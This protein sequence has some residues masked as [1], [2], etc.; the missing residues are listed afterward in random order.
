MTKSF[1]GY[2]VTIFLFVLIL[3]SAQIVSAQQT[4]TSRAEPPLGIEQKEGQLHQDGH[5]MW[6]G[7]NREYYYFDPG[8]SKDSPLPLVILF[9][10][11]GGTID[12]LLGLDGSKSAAKIWLDVAERERFYLVIPQGRDGRWNDCRS[13]CATCPE[14]NDVG[15]IDTIISEMSS[16]YSINSNRIY[17][18]GIS[19]GGMFSFRLARELSHRIA[20]V[21]TVIANTPA[22]NE[23]SSPNLPVPVMMI[24]GTND[25]IVPYHGGQSSFQNTGTFL[26]AAETANFWITHN[27]CSNTPEIYQFPDGSF[28][29]NSTVTSNLYS[30][31]REG[32]E[33]MVYHVAGGGHTAPSIEEQYSPI[34]EAIVGK[35]NHDIETA[36]EIWSFF[37]KYQLD[38]PLTA[39]GE[40]MK[41]AIMI[42]LDADK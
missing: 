6:E 12:K 29:D 34:Y 31:G 9:H 4:S 1:S 26:S 15:L 27:G 22:A 5:V 30:N 23:C 21:A 14:D 13:D 3:T 37:S 25:V 42:L 39:P 16:R 24:V 41:G 18:T 36:E 17:A 10:G 40:K 20:A 38:G 7:H 2:R 19:N 35:Q 11:G 32:T 28:N 8:G 33:V